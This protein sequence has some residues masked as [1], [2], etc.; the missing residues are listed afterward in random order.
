MLLSY[1]AQ[2]F[3]GHCGA[4]C[5]V[6]SLAKYVLY[7]GKGSFHITRGGSF[8][9]FFWVPP[10]PPKKI[11]VS[12]ERRRFRRRLRFDNYAGSFAR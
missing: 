9:F 3:V 1:R 4:S 6:H 8:V 2:C 11:S 10:P 12:P 7:L 5:E